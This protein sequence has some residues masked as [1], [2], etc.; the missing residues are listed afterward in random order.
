MKTKGDTTVTI[1]SPLP[2]VLIL[3]R[4]YCG[5]VLFLCIQAINVSAWLVLKVLE[6]SL[7]MTLV[8]AAT[9]LDCNM[10]FQTGMFEELF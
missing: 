1:F 8:D 4:V 10:I 2:A 5:I 3:L 7:G 6:K 9:P